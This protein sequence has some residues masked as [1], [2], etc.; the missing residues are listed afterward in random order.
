MAT[1]TKILAAVDFSEATPA[2][3]AYACTLAKRYAA[4]VLVLN[5]TP[6]LKRYKRFELSPE[7]IDFF[8]NSIL[9]DAE[10]KMQQCLQTLFLDVR[11]TGRV[12]MGYAPEI[13]LTV[14]TEEN[15]DL[16]VLGTHGRQGLNRM[17]FGSVAEKVLKAATIPVLTVRP[18]KPISPDIAPPLPFAGP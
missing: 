2:V 8:A 16:I 3:A 14:A 18:E 12:L 17:L 1:I 4:E 15:A 13:I 5:A 9:Y 6:A 7:N 10:K 11:A